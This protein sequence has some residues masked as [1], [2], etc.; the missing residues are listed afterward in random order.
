M[1]PTGDAREEGP[2]VEPPA[3]PDPGSPEPTPPATVVQNEWGRVDAAGSVFVRTDDGEHQVGSWQV[4]EPEQALAFFG[5]KYD[6][7]AVQV[8]LL[9]QRLGSGAAAPDETASGVRKLREAMVEPHAVGD[10]GTLSRRLDTVEAR[11]AERRAER[12]AER[13]QA[14]GQARTRKE[15]IAAEAATIAEGDD[16]RHGADRLRALLDEWKTLARLDRATDDTLW[17]KFSSARTHYTRRRK[18][19]FAEVAEHREQAKAVKQEILAEAEAL[20]ESTDW[21]ATARRYRELMARWKAAGPAPKPADDALWKRFRAAQD[22]FFTARTA[23]LSKRDTEQQTNLDAKQELL[24]EAESLLP[25]TDWKAARETLRSIHDR[26][27]AAGHVPRDA[28]RS[29][30]GRLRR[31]EDAVR[32]AE[33]S[34]WRRTNPEALARAEATVTQLRSSIGD[35]EKQAAAARERD[36]PRKLKE[37]EDALAARRSWLEQ[38]ERALDEF[39]GG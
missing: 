35:L 13:A 37:A 23:D 39:G 14:L 38:A 3:S 18:T 19:H 12:R 17:R 36:D 11:I 22:T 27:E 10:L 16:W 20:A 5:R 6:D 9:E 29:I 1:I 31:V 8:D 15:S 21:A 32:D 25:V 7:L 30:E 33:Q 24:A 34:E 2:V 26:W 28:M 4:G